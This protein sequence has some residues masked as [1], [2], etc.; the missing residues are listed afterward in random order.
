MID[1]LLRQIDRIEGQI[2]ELSGE[3]S[4]RKKK[5]RDLLASDIVKDIALLYDRNNYIIYL[6]DDIYRIF[7]EEWMAF[8]KAEMFD[9]EEKETLYGLEVRPTEMVEPYIIAFC[10]HKIKTGDDYEV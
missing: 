9:S 10:P 3:R 1:L 8:F 4:Q 7:Y 2:E 6:R 5:V